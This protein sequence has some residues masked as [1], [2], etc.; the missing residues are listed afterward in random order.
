MFAIGRQETITIHRDE[1]KTLIRL[2]VEERKKAGLAQREVARRIG[3]PQSTIWLI[4]KGERRLD[5]L[6][7]L[8]LS[9]A[10]GFGPGELLALVKELHPSIYPDHG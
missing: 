7:F 1:Y 6:E 4:E 8:N 9:V 2:I 10:I 5:V 3:L